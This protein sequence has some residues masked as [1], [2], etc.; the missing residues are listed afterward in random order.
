LAG[1]RLVWRRL[2][3]AGGAGRARNVGLDAAGCPHV[4][5]VDADD[6][7]LPELG[8]LMADLDGQEFDFAIFRHADS[9]AIALGGQGPLEPDASLW[10]RIAAGAAPRPLDG[11]Q[12]RLL[13]RI[14]AYPWNKVYRTAFLRG[15]AIRFTEIPVHNDLALHWAC[16]IAARRVLASDRICCLHQVS[17][18]GQ[19]LTLRRDSDRLRV[20]EALDEV[21]ARLRA[22]ADA[23]RF[24]EPFV[25]FCL[26]LFD[27]IP[28][29]LD[30]PA[31][32]DEFALRSG[33]F[34]GALGADFLAL[35]LLR[36]PSL[37]GPAIARLRAAA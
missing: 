17:D 27:W 18:D 29:R 32:R 31:A 5:F 20:F 3:D 9:R 7:L 12:T 1:E 26:R 30:S 28:A 25:E 24:A 34:L 10:R 36:N 19:H 23:G 6:R 4:M 37:A 13:C 11:A 21:A 16:F 22:T 8:P 14:S 15:E 2:E 33:R 35:A